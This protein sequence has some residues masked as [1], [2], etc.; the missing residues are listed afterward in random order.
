MGRWM[1]LSVLCL[2]CRVEFSTND[3]PKALKAIIESTPCPA[4]RSGRHSVPDELERLIEAEAKEAKAP[5]AQ[6]FFER[7]LENG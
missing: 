3:G 4:V 7:M 1:R 2:N 5:I 6:P